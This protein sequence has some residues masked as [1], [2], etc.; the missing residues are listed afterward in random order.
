LR[1]AKDQD[2]NGR[3]NQTTQPDELMAYQQAPQRNAVKRLHAL[4]A[5]HD[6]IQ[7]L[8]STTTQST[9]DRNERIAL[10]VGDVAVDDVSGA[11]V[12]AVDVDVAITIACS[13]TRWHQPTSQQTALYVYR[14]LL[15]LSIEEEKSTR[16]MYL[17]RK[18]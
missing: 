8:S 4:H 5:Q 17:N 7:D 12:D 13:S 6:P 1:A 3:A 16:F 9:H 10:V 11:V 2:I 18:D 14:I 15:R